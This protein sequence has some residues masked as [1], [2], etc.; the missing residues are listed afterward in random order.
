MNVQI[1]VWLFIY[2]HLFC[3]TGVFFLHLLMRRT[4][5]GGNCLLGLSYQTCVLNTSWIA[6]VSFTLST[7][8]ALHGLFADSFMYVLCEEYSHLPLNWWN[9]QQYHPLQ[10]TAKRRKKKQSTNR[11]NL[12]LSWAPQIIL[13]HV[14]KLRYKPLFVIVYECFLFVFFYSLA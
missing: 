3:S 13:S 8:F 1:N 14:L 6:V 10:S 9:K 2:F 5:V 12:K 11:N 7:C 4:F